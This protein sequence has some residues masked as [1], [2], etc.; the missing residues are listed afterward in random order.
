[1][2]YLIIAVLLGLLAVAICA[3]AL[4]LLLGSWLLQ[5]LRGTA[6]LLVLAVAVLVALAAWDLRSYR[7]IV[8]DKPIATLAFAQ[9]EDRHFAVTL[10]DQGGSEQRVA[11]DGDMWQLDVRVLRVP[12]SLAQLGLKS[13]F[14]LARVSGRY[15]SLEDE[16]RLP[17]STIEL[18]QTA[19]LFDVWSWLQRV[20]RYFSPLEAVSASA[21]YLPMIDGAMYSVLVE[22]GS[23][24][25]Y[26]LNDH[27]KVAL[28][29]WD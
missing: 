16:Q 9:L 21:S 28:E 27:T 7:S 11:L 19:P 23:V 24:V 12:E 13:G 17:R 22:A 4:R 29:R 2:T 20:N 10:V 25:V 18:N 1:M 3:L 6:G 26:P 14:R 15:L 5:W 8:S